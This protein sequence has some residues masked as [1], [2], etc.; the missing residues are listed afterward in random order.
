MPDLSPDAAFMRRALQV[1]ELGWGQTAPNPMVGAVVVAGDE[2]V[3]EGYHARYGDAHAE[4]VALRAAGTRARDATVYVTLE[5]CAHF[6]KTPPCVDAL[7]AAGVARVVIA[8]RDPSRIARGGA[9]RLRAA[10]IRVDEDVERD[11]ALELNAPFFNAHVSNRPWITLKLAMSADGAIADPTGVRR[12]ITGPESR[13]EVHRMR[14]NSDAILTGIGTVLADNPELTVRDSVQPR[15]PPTR[16]AL[17]RQLRLPL[18]TRLVHSA[19]MTPTLVFTD[20]EHVESAAASRLRDAGVVVESIV[21]GLPGVFEWLRARDIRSVLVESGPRLT[22]ALLAESL[23]D[24]L[25]IFQSS[26]V[27]GDRAPRAFELAPPGFESSLAARRIVDQRRFG[28][29]LMTA[30]GFRDVPCSPD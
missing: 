20:A 11:R 24:R 14:A 4:V 29:D 27:L 7:I 18:A 5:P 3:G 12:W 21:G 23:V 15:V 2:I 19:R 8:V 17:D 1:A 22:G 13:A 10:G 25:V 28:P 16:V 30:Y 9:E 26:L 6:G